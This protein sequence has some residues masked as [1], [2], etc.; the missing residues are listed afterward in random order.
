M[1]IPNPNPN[2][3]DGAIRDNK[4]WSS[5]YISGKI[6]EATE[7]P[8]VTGEDNGKVLTVSSGSWAAVLPTPMTD[9]IDDTGT[10]E[11]TV[12]SSDK[13]DE[14]LSAIKDYSTTETAI[15]KWINGET[16]YRKV[17]TIP[18]VT[19]PQDDGVAFTISNYISDVDKII[20]HS[21]ML[22]IESEVLNL[23]YVHVDST[24]SK[25][26]ISYCLSNATLRVSRGDFTA[27]TGTLIVCL[28]Y[29]KTA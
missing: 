7:L 12:W 22:D 13:T 1:A 21:I 10:S 9:I 6:V 29:I 27:V 11:T 19:V 24:N 20:N 8:V 25:Y 18:N 23:P 3:E 28:E 14:E 26:S 15:G 4:T 17:F 5:T 16:I 2:I